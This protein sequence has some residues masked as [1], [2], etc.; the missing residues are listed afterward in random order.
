MEWLEGN[1]IPQRQGFESDLYL[2]RDQID[3]FPLGES[4]K[5]F[6]NTVIYEHPNWCELLPQLSDIHVLVANKC[7][8]GLIWKDILGDKYGFLEK[9]GRYIIGW[10]YI[11]PRKNK[12]ENDIHYIDFI[13]STIKGHNIAQIMI[14]KYEKDNKVSLFPEEIIHSSSK[15][16]SKKMIIE[17]ED[18]LIYKQDIDQFIEENSIDKD[19]IKWNSLYEICVDNEVN[20]T[21]SDYEDD[22]D[23]DV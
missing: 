14:N 22:E 8:G 21:D 4:L 5:E 3:M 10:M 19:R 18:G 2:I 16:W 9:H 12:E 15:Y 20:P 7:R 13:D 11:D 17:D 6:I 1:A 23:D